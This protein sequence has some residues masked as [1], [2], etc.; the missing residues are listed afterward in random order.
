M[1]SFRGAMGRHGQA[2]SWRGQWTGWIGSAPVQISGCGLDGAL[3]WC[4]QGEGQSFLVS[5]WAARAACQTK[6][7]PR[8]RF[9]RAL[10]AFICTFCMR[11]C[12]YVYVCMCVDMIYVYICMCV[13]IR[14]LCVYTRVYGYVYAYLCIDCGLGISASACGRCHACACAFVCI[15]MRIHMCV[16][17][18][19][20]AFVWSECYM[21]LTGVLGTSAWAGVYVTQVCFYTNVHICEHTRSGC[22]HMCR[23]IY[24]C[25]CMH[26]HMDA[27]VRLWYCLTRLGVVARIFCLCIVHMHAYVYV[28]ACMC[29]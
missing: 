27:Y 1:T 22:A 21:H 7:L 2:G 8:R 20:C 16:G 5:S 9:R 23:C 15:C 13:C 14:N 11:V 28:C 3:S 25:I 19:I 17:I 4:G 29:V 10:R 24:V 18:Y 26:M 12:I 6:L